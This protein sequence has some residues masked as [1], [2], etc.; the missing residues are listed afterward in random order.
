MS[1]SMF[2]SWPY[3]HS[4]PTSV[5]PAPSVGAD[6]GHDGER[7]LSFG[8]PLPPLPLPPLLPLPLPLPLLLSVP[9]SVPPPPPREEVEPPQ[10]ANATATHAADTRRRFIPSIIPWQGRADASE[11]REGPAA[12]RSG[13]EPRPAP[14]ARARG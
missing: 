11:H 6:A 3:S 14:S 9:P 12:R 8:P 4:S 10:A 13:L 5:Q 7:P 2:T 1:Q